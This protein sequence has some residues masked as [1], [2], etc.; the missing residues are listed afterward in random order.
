MKAVRKII[1]GSPKGE[2]EKTEGTDFAILLISP[3]FH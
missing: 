1:I 3:S 2:I